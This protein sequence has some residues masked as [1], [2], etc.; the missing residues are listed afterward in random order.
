MPAWE[1][2]RSE[3]AFLNFQ[4]EFSCFTELKQGE[5][6]PRPA[7]AVTDRISYQIVQG[8]FSPADRC[9]R[10]AARFIVLAC[11]VS[12][13]FAIAQ[14]ESKKP[15]DTIQKTESKNTDAQK[16]PRVTTTVEVHDVVKDDYFS[17]A[18]TAGSLDGTLLKETP[19]SV[20]SITRAVLSDQVAR[21]LS[22]VVKNDASV[23][24]DY[25]PV[26][27][28]GDFE[29]RGFPLDLATALQ[30]DGMTIAGEQDVPLENKESVEIVK[31]VAG[32]ESGVA[33]SGGLIDYVTKEPSA[34]QHPAIDMATDHRGTSYGALDVGHVFQG[35][36]EPG[37]RL[38]L[39]GEDMH[40]YV[41]HAD[42][43]R[44]MG[45]ADSVL[46]LGASTNLFS[47]FEYQHKVQRSEAG[48]Q[49]LG[50]T[51][52]PE[53]VFPS[54]M[55]G[56]QSWSKPNTFDVFN[57]GSRL[58][59][60]FNPKWTGRLNGSYSHSLID[61][62]VIWP[63]GPAL[64]ANGNSLCPDA[65]Y[66]F[67]C[68]DGSYEIY[69]YR[70][71]G[72]LRIDAVG[73][74]LV[75]GHITTGKI[76]QDVF[77]GGSLFHRSVDLSS[78]IVYTPL[79]V[80][81]VFQPNI[82][83]APESPYQQADPA[84]LA[85]FD[86]QASGILQ[87]RVHFPAGV[88]ALAGGRFVRVGDFNY[89]KARTLWLPQYALTYALVKDMT[90]YGNY[91]VLL[92]LGQQAPWWVD[93]AN[94]FLDPF[95][96]RQAEVGVK[97]ERQILLTADLFR[98][99]Q[100]FFYPRVIQ[101]PDAFCTSNLSTGGS[102]APGDLCFESDGHETHDGVELS[103][104]GKAAGWLQLTG[105]ATAMNAKSTGTGTAAFDHKQVIN[106][107]RVHTTLFADMLVPHTSGLHLMPGWSYT[108]TKE[109]TRDD[110]VSV[111]GYNLFNLG[112]R[113]TPRG[114]QGHMTLRL[115]ADNIFNK[116][117]WKD[118]GASYGDTFI[119]QGAP[120]TV[121]LSAHYVF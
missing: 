35:G 34:K 89:A 113:Y 76:A 53:P 91:G 22:D 59:H 15:S 31:G 104:Q 81:N 103:A 2:F 62:N 94:Q 49:L 44:G 71:P 70:S 101:V 13:L 38:N 4:R 95:S 115:Y 102:I 111:P 78:S 92:S 107:P 73:E 19:L 98:M 85:D 26:G 24:E 99:R 11:F 100:P 50:G 10:W 116:R 8:I 17:G 28:Y 25:A 42:G 9:M 83:Y 37:V 46:R 5:R 3:A 16:L 80:E 88:T 66:Y 55:L 112:A 29:I 63:Y 77:G 87:D 74:A 1:V 14:S 72:E 84:T 56:Y 32:V 97:Y 105:S 60:R 33:S 109:A 117:Y 121:R 52:V 96:T 65:P 21:V 61:D 40:T 54:T 30:I 79:G 110:A 118:T 114:E 57:A 93:N 64:D 39:A 12:P 86:H 6:M 43:W 47:D 90:L 69:D 82:A 18:T 45:A 58:E 48:Y 67:F 75:T 7:T 20:T 41:Q 36:L 119:H 27:Y 68:P 120:A 23:G 51:T 106:V 108:S